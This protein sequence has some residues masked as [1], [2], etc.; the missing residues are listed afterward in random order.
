MATFGDYKHNLS[1]VNEGITHNVFFCQIEENQPHSLLRLLG[2]MRL[3]VPYRR[4]RRQQN[5]T[6]AAT[7]ERNGSDRFGQQQ[8]RDAVAVFGKCPICDIE[9]PNVTTIFRIQHFQTN[10][11]SATSFLRQLN[12][13]TR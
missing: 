5:R 4:R 8:R 7:R 3:P 13:F 9:F 11:F 10:I 1:V 12:N 2:E 6:A